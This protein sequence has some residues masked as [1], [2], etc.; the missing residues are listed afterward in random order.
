MKTP[1]IDYKS[2]I[3]SGKPYTD[4][5]SFTNDSL[6]WPAKSTGYLSAYK[7]GTNFD[8]ARARSK[9]PTAT[10]WGKTN[11]AEP[12]GIKQGSLGDCYFIASCSA[13]TEFSNRFMNSFVT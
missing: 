4:D 13:T 3:G 1:T 6:Y 2:I 8:L 12:N 11:K 9:L 10:L 5:F 7:A